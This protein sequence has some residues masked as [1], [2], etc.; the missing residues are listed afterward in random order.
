MLLNLQSCGKNDILPTHDIKKTFGFNYDDEIEALKKRVGTLEAQMQTNISNISLIQSDIDSIELDID[1]LQSVITTLEMHV[2]DNS[3]AIA[4]LQSQII[5]HSSR[6]TSLESLV[7][8]LQTTTNN[9]LVDVA[10]LENNENIVQFIDPCLDGPG[11]DEVLLK[12][13]SGKLVAY[14]ETGSKRFLSLL[15]PGSYRTTDQQGCNFTVHGNMSV[16]W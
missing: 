11:F 2:E 6:I 1:S 5:N 10:Q 13:S 14:F 3:A 15:T 16:T 8:S 4:L 12:T 9:L 7:A